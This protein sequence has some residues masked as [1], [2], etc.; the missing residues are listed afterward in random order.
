MIDVC[1]SLFDVLGFNCLLF[2]CS[3]L[4]V[5]VC[6]FVLRAMVF[7]V[8]RVLCIVCFRGLFIVVRWS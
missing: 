4:C 5:V 7:V 3:G 2:I 8:C 1:C 6:C